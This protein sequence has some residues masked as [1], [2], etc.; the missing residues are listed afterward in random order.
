MSNSVSTVS[1]KLFYEKR[2]SKK[3]EGYFD[4]I[5]A[6]LGYRQMFL[7]FD[8]GMIAELLHC[9]VSDLYSTAP[10]TKIEVGEISCDGVASA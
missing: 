5:Y 9:S 8:R 4:V 3:G 7:I 2:K 10:G 1:V 6:E